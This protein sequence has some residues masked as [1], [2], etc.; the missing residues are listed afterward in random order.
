MFG[1]STEYRSCFLYTVQRDCPA[2]C[3][4]CH[5]LEDSI[6]RDCGLLKQLPVGGL[7]KKANKQK[8]KKGPNNATAE[9]KQKQRQKQNKDKGKTA[10]NV[11]FM[12]RLIAC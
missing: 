12:A 10:K 5:L 6:V 7:V 3:Q 1:T 9:A 8:T 2:K 11:G 4:S